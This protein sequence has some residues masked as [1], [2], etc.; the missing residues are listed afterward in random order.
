MVSVA[1]RYRYSD[2]IT[3]TISN[4]QYCR[5]V[6][7]P[8]PPFKSARSVGLVPETSKSR[9]NPTVFKKSFVPLVRLTVESVPNVSD[10]MVNC[11]MLASKAT[12]ADPPIT[13]LHLGY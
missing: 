8:L 13:R 12:V 9:S 10:V 5:V 3:L 1:V 11:P 7:T 2:S 4:S 6:T